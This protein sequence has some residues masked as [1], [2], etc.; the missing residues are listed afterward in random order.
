MYVLLLNCKIGYIHGK[1][2]TGQQIRSEVMERGH[3]GHGRSQ[4]LFPKGGGHEQA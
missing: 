1:N 2:M 4:N 3:E